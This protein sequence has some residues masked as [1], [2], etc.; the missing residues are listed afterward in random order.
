MV[1][2]QT[3]LLGQRLEAPVVVPAL[4][5]RVLDPAH[6]C[7]RVGGLVQERGHHRACAAAETFAANKNLRE[8]LMLSD[9]PALCGKVT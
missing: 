9:L 6:V 4:A 3:E 8:R 2:V 7:E 1:D 5:A